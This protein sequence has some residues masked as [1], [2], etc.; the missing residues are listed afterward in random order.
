MTVGN[1]VGENKVS[2]QCAYPDVTAVAA[3]DNPTRV[4]K[5]PMMARTTARASRT[6]GTAE[7][8]GGNRQRPPGDASG[9][10]QP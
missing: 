7:Y 1:A 9:C 10:R 8:G 5:R 6:S 3:P 4:S 2:I